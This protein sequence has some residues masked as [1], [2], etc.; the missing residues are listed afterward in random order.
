MNEYNASCDECWKGGR[1]VH[2][3]N[4][5]TNMY[6]KKGFVTYLSLF[7]SEYFAQNQQRQIFADSLQFWADVSGLTFSEV[8][9]ASTAD[10]KIR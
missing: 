9:S 8:S 7:F 3:V 6:L 1:T 4:V 5:Y 2:E 10:I